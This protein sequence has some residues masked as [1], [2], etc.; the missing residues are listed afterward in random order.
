MIEPTL[1]IIGTTVVQPIATIFIRRVWN[2]SVAYKTDLIALMEQVVW[3]ASDLSDYGIVRERNGCKTDFRM[4]SCVNAGRASLL[5]REGTINASN[6]A[7]GFGICL[8]WWC[9]VLVYDRKCGTM[10]VDVDELEIF[11][12]SA[13]RIVI[14]CVN[15]SMSM[16]SHSK[17]YRLV[18]ILN[19]VRVNK[20]V[21]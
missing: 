15:T 4:R 19:T 21:R 5:D 14:L 17:M 6:S 11:D 18:F 9:K 20:I 12:M 1:K 16:W 2:T 7:G 3:I 13:L 8:M 10:G